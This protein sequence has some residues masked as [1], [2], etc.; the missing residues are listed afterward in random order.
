MVEIF[1]SY[2]QKPLLYWESSKKQ[3]KH[4]VSLLDRYV[5]S[6]FNTMELLFD[7]L[8]TLLSGYQYLVLSLVHTIWRY[9]EGLNQSLE[10]LNP[11]LF[12]QVMN[13]PMVSD[14][15]KKWRTLRMNTK[16]L[17]RHWKPIRKKCLGSSDRIWP[18]NLQKKWMKACILCNKIIVRN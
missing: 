16:L 7:C 9:C 12:H 5:T 11:C 15:K 1:C 18:L 4:W 8:K 14:C 13:K 2:N 3:R 10:Y 17:S 6:S